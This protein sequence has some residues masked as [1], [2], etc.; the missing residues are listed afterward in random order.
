MNRIFDWYI[1][2]NGTEYAVKGTIKLGESSSFIRTEPIAAALYDRGKNL[3]MITLVSGQMY[4]I[5]SDD[6]YMGRRCHPPQE[7]VD[8]IHRERDEAVRDFCEHFGFA[9]LADEMISAKNERIRLLE[10]K[11]ERLKQ[12]LPENTL[13]LALRDSGYYF[14]YGVYNV[15]GKIGNCE[16][17]SHSGTFQDSIIVYGG[18]DMDMV[19]LVRFFPLEKSSVRFYQTLMQIDEH[20]VDGTLLGYL[21]NSGTSPLNVQFTWG[22]HILLQ[23]GEET[24]VRYGMG[25]NGNIPVV[26]ERIEETRKR[27]HDFM[28]GNG[29]N[30]IQ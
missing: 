15:D 25:E 6:M 18:K 1:K 5:L 3:I 16:M 11:I 17:Y 20:P 12:M 28:K 23:P 2:H 4:T 14:H 10:E 19:D 26:N 13:Y 7:W 21:F 29:N 8:N 27:F 22:K 24:E 30:I 9:E